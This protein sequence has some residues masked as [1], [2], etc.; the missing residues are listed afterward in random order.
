MTDDDGDDDTPSCPSVTMSTESV[1]GLD[2]RGVTVEVDG[3]DGDTVADVSE[4]A[5]E[6]FEQAVA[7]T[8]ATDTSPRG[9]E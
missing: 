2:G 1:A 5:A 4:V 3:G 9:Y 8:E 6:R 7:A